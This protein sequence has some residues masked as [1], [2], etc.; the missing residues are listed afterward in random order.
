MSFGGAVGGAGG[1]AAGAE[2][3]AAG[4][5][6]LGGIM[7]VAGVAQKS[8]LLGG[9]A[10]G[11]LSGAI[12]GASMGSMVGP[13]GTAIGAVLGGITGL[14]GSNDDP[15]PQMP[16]NPTGFKGMMPPPTSAS[17]AD[18]PSVT[19]GPFAPHTTPQPA[20]MPP[21]AQQSMPTTWG[22]G[23]NPNGSPPPLPQQSMPIKPE[24][25]Q[26]PGAPSASN[27][28]TPA[29]PWVTGIAA[30]APVLKAAMGGNN[31]DP[32]GMRAMANAPA[33]S[34]RGGEVVPVKVGMPVKRGPSPIERFM[35][36]LKR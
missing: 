18:V 23:I 27:Q 7:N 15:G 33:P 24:P 3:A 28:I 21:M 35:A 19:S 4:G 25:P 29:N 17:M 9:K 6:G 1:A 20:S 8:G 5:N 14:M 34:L 11:L 22:A 30:S 32:Y 26:M 2:A 31:S 16:S 10:G 36:T 12:S 13:Y